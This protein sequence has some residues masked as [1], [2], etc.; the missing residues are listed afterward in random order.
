MLSCARPRRPSQAEEPA[1]PGPRTG[2]AASTP[3][4]LRV[5]GLVAAGRSIPDIAAELMVSRPTDQTHVSQHPAQARPDLARGSAPDGTM[6]AGELSFV[7]NEQ[8]GPPHAYQMTSSR[9]RPSTALRKRK[10]AD[11]S[12]IAETTMET[13]YRV[14]RTML[15]QRLTPG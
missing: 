8:S 10:Y 2:W 13:M 4:E 14:A 12:P 6:I 15:I 9:S 5:A 1:P 3:S 7:G 11:V